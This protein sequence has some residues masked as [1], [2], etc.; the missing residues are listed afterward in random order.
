MGEVNSFRDLLLLLY[1]V[2]VVSYQFF[3]LG[4]FLSCLSLEALST[5]AFFRST[6]LGESCS[7]VAHFFFYVS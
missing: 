6:F 2:F 5:V 3:F 4:D 7:R 1:K